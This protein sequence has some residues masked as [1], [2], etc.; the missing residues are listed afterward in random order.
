MTYTEWRFAGLMKTLT[1][2]E[3]RQFLDQLALPLFANRRDKGHA[4]LSGFKTQDFEVVTDVC[5]NFASGKM[6]TYFEKP[7]LAFL[8][9]WFNKSAEGKNFAKNK[10][11]KQNKRVSGYI[12]DM[13]KGIAYYAGE[14]RTCLT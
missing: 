12:D 4:Y 5:D 13:R 3:Q 7:T 9:V 11:T 2:H 1:Q 6:K 10:F 14:A 8:F